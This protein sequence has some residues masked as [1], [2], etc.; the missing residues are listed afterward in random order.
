MKTTPPLWRRLALALW[1]GCAPLLAALHLYPIREGF[2]RLLILSCYAALLGLGTALFWQRR[3][4]RFF[5]ALGALI[6]A[7]VCLVPGR[8]ADANS[9]RVRYTTALRAYDGTPYVWGGE[10][11]RGIDCSGLLRRAYID[12]NLREGLSRANPQP[13]RI[14]FTLW[15]RDCSAL[16][17]RD[18]YRGWTQRRFATPSLNRLDYAQLRPGDLAVTTGGGHCLAYLGQKTW[19]E[20]DPNLATGDKVI[21]VTVPSRIAWFSTPMQIVRWRELENGHAHE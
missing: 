20:A 10:T 16:A 1:L 6:L 9:L 5:A 19:I 12:A 18:E 2:S 17:M 15:L 8:A 7:A 4:V 13:L 11:A 14:A 21:T 3:G